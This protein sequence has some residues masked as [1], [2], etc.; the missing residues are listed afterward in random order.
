M[1]VANVRRKPKQ[2]DPGPRR[3]K[4]QR[5]PAKRPRLL[6]VGSDE[7]RVDEIAD[8]LDGLEARVE[9]LGWEQALESLTEA[10]AGVVLVLPVERL[11][12]TAA[13][14]IVR[15]HPQGASLPLHGVVS[16]RVSSRQ[17]RKLYSAGATVILEWP[18]EASI[19]R[20]L[21]AESYGIS[22]VR[23]RARKADLSLTR[24]VRAHLRIFP[25]L[26]SG[27]LRLFARDGLVSVSGE[28]RS[29]AQRLEIID[30]VG[31]VPGVRSVLAQSLRV[32][33]S[34]IPDRTLK[35][36]IEAQ[37]KDASDLDKSTISVQVRNG[38]VQLTGTVSERADIQSLERLVVNLRGTRG[39]ERRLTVSPDRQSKDHQLSRRYRSAL[40]NLYPREDLAL[41]V[42]AGVAIVSGTV[43][44][45]SIKRSIERL[46]AR[47]PSIRRVV[48]KVE[49]T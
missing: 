30:G 26:D 3:A 7:T 33:P 2:T 46:M 39:L 9:K 47:D 42:V 13:V 40:N 12:M 48:N 10:V 18:R 5:E 8:A 21:F 23:G 41:S 22:R 31:A 43:R 34:K 32:A 44:S 20:A 6:I 36:R 29:L 27:R 28:V 45:L 25:E 14:E 1:T 17:V 19:F 35:R 4:K 37:I 16:D 24:S 11:S 49:V 38:H 15:D